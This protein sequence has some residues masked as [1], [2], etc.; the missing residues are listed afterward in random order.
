MQLQSA[1]APPGRSHYIDNSRN[2]RSVALGAGTERRAGA[3]RSDEARRNGG[4]ER[5][6][7]GKYVQGARETRET[8]KERER[9]TEKS[10]WYLVPGRETGRAKERG[11]GSEKDSLPCPSSTNDRHPPLFPFTVPLPLRPC[12]LSPPKL[13]HSPLLPPLPPLRLPTSV[14]HVHPG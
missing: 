12:T 13:V 4:K 9:K 5:K 14:R 3:E 6:E 7:R 1:G 11:E 2:A 8:E 10:G